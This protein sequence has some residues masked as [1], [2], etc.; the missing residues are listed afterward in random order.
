M[1]EAQEKKLFTKSMLYVMQNPIMV[2]P[3]YKDS[4]NNEMVMK[5]FADKMKNINQIMKTQLAGTMD[6]CIYLS[7][8]SMIGPLTREQTKIYFHCFSKHYDLTK[9]LEDEKEREFMI[10]LDDNE[11]E[12]MQKLQ[13][14]I[15][16]GN[17]RRLEK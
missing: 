10:N 15:F 7:C 5:A 2:P 6:L 12:E 13:R 3:G 1:N 9:I 11:I 17:M 8:M 4:L 16:R 14:S